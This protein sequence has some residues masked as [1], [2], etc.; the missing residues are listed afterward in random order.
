MKKQNI[1]QSY[2]K[3]KHKTI[4]C[5]NQANLQ[6]L[7][8]IQNIYRL[9][10]WYLMPLSTIFQLYRGCQFY[11]WRKPRVPEENHRPAASD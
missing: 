11:W 8:T 9:G 3:T 5:K 7:K 6:S 2:V 1:K 10:V 4:L